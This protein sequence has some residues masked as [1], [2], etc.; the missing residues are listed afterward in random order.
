MNIGKLLVLIKLNN[1]S[2]ASL[3]DNVHERVLFAFVYE[4][5]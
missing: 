1:S 4:H 2:A 3:G 5:G